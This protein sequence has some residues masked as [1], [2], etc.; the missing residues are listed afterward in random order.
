MRTIESKN[1]NQLA[2]IF[3]Y[4]N[5]LVKHPNEYSKM[6][7]IFLIIAGTFPA[8]NLWGQKY[9]YQ[10]PNLSSEERA[11]DLISRLSLEEKATLML[12]LH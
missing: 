3:F 8:F 4:L 6:T 5:L 9:P 2:V 1:K 7:K 11:K 10:D 12:N